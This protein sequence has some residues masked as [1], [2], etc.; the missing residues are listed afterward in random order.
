M[1]FSFSDDFLLDNVFKEVKHEMLKSVDL[2]E[3]LVYIFKY[4]IT[5]YIISYFQ[6]SLIILPFIKKPQQ[7]LNFIL[8]VLEH[9]VLLCPWFYVIILFLYTFVKSIGFT[10]YLE[11]F[12]SIKTKKVTF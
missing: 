10:F 2:H 12:S 4:F 11:N 6:L 8:H 5:V 9:S 7:T 3:Y 1:K